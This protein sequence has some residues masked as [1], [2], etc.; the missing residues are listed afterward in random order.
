MKLNQQIYS[1]ID[2]GGI[3]IPLCVHIGKIKDSDFYEVPE[4]KTLKFSYKE[5]CLDTTEQ[6]NFFYGKFQEFG[7]MWHIAEVIWEFI[8]YTN[9]ERFDYLTVILPKEKDDFARMIVYSDIISQENLINAYQELLYY[10]SVVKNAFLD[11][12]IKEL[13]ID[14]PYPE[15]ETDTSSDHTKTKTYKKHKDKMSPSL[16]MINLK[17]VMRYEGE[18][19]FPE[20]I[21]RA[22]ID[23]SWREKEIRRLFEKKQTDFDNFIESVKSAIMDDLR[24]DMEK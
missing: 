12:V 7:K 23:Y 8:D 11:E 13:E 10:I 3:L 24:K 18:V 21:G 20:N 15:V 14:V 22:A 6:A 4:M 5:R 9:I 17:L 19:L 2:L 1:H 16:N